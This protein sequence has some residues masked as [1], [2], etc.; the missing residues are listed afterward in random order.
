MQLSAIN[1]NSNNKNLNF[2]GVKQKTVAKVVQKNKTEIIKEDIVKYIKEGLTNKDLA[3]IYH[4]NPDTIAITLYK[5]G[6]MH[7][8]KEI[9]NIITNKNRNTNT[10]RNRNIS[11]EELQELVA[12]GLKIKD[13]AK[14]FN[15][16]N[17]A[18]NKYL[19]KFGLMDEYR[20]INKI[21][22]SKDELQD[23]VLNGFKINDIA[24]KYNCCS[25]TIKDRL[26]KFGLMQ[27][28]KEINKINIAKKE[29]QELVIQGFK[30]KEIALK[31]NCSE[32]T[33]SYR[34][35]Q[36]GLMNEYKKIQKTKKQNNPQS[37]TNNS[38][39]KNQT[40]EKKITKSQDAKK[41]NNS[42]I[43]SSKQKT[44]KT[45]VKKV[46]KNKPSQI[47][48]DKIQILNKQFKRDVDLLKQKGISI[49]TLAEVFGLPII[50]TNPLNSLDKPNNNVK[51]TNNSNIAK[52]TKKP[53]II[54]RSPQKMSLTPEAI[55]TRKKENK[56]YS[57]ILEQRGIIVTENKYGQLTISEYKQPPKNAFAKNKVS[58]N[59]LLKNVIEITGNADFEKSDITELLYIKNIGGNA[60]LWKSQ[61]QNLGSLQTVGG[62]LELYGSKLD[63][64]G[65][66]T[67]VVGDLSFRDSNITDISNVKEIG[68]TVY[69]KNSKL[70]PQDFGHIKVKKFM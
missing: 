19:H 46:L 62:N 14:Q 45:V 5:F 34:L 67:S 29:L 36:L 8:Y 52:E 66:L 25:D 65:L 18:I 15:R 40:Q 1:Y 38:T 63:N 58:E 61:I 50:F 12:K 26:N 54:I 59:E 60:I 17:K 10:N 55:N 32:P 13:I 20:E 35:Y 43:A 70:K 3:K 22:I 21:N 7:E 11:K 39:T 69:L 9:H 56:I 27:K 47:I 6:L 48:N 49:Y 28:Y 24:Q 31:Y 23:L 51:N 57:K 64:L 4:C 33:I 2:E 68:G 41:G 30:I 16:G 37:I 53:K 44:P 42:I